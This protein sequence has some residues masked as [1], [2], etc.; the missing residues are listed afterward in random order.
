MMFVLKLEDRHRENIQSQYADMPKRDIK[1]FKYTKNY[2]ISI[3]CGGFVM[4]I[5]CGL[6]Y[7][8]IEFFTWLG[9]ERFLYGFL[10]FV[11]A[12]I[13]GA[14]FRVVYRDVRKDMKKDY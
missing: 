6:S 4:G 3:F 11:I 8:A 14:I 10:I 9:A 12:P 7:C 1:I 2:V 5:V 13:L